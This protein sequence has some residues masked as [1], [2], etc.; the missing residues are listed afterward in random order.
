MRMHFLERQLPPHQPRAADEALEQHLHRR[1]RLLA[2]R[3]FEVA[4]LDDGDR[5]VRRAE[6]MVL[7]ADWNG[8]LERFHFLDR[9]YSS[10]RCIAA[11]VNSACGWL[12]PM[13]NIRRCS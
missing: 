12:P 5:R 8:Q 4:V 2:I 1:R 11:G 13:M 9:A 10:Q 7:R 6:V 3:A